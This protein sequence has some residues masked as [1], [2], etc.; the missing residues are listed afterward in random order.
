MP[1]LLDLYHAMPYPLQVLAASLR[2]YR[3]KHLRYGNETERLVAE[4]LERD[5]WSADHWKAWQ[6]ERLAFLLH[7]A[8]TRVPYYRVLWE[9]RRL[10]GDTSSSDILENWPILEKETV[11]RKPE[12]FVA[13]DCDR[14]KMFVDSTSGTTG[15]PLRV[16]LRPETVRQ[17]YALFEARM[18]RKHGVSLKDRWAIMGGQLVAPFDR[19]SPP[20]WVYNHP[21]NQLYLST[22]HLSEHTAADYVAALRRFQPTHMLVYPSSANVLAAAMLKQGLTPP[23]LNVIFTNAEQLLDTQRITIEQAFGCPV[24]N[25]YGLCEI[26]A[27]GGECSTHRMH[28]W[29]EAGLIEILKDEGNARAH[30]GQTG[31]IIAT[32][33]LNADMPLIR[34][35]VGDRGA[36]GA[37]SQCGCGSHL[38]AISALEGRMNDLIVTP[39]GRKVFWLNPTFYGLPVVES[40]IIQEDQRSLRVLIA[41]GQGFCKDHLSTISERLQQRV[42]GMHILYEVVDRVPRTANGKLRGV[43]S[44]LQSG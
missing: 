19:K 14:K 21:L 23:N 20:F 40:Q 5:S 25:T 27:A 1:T 7:R 15:T 39:D 34:Y 4:A 30:P 16:Y 22:H 17:W 3:L 13:D 10:R 44:R 29:P 42:G 32:G 35:Q 28:I 11:R 24:Y 36:V 31:R 43:V 37:G 8:A 33:L 38:P 9:R 12:A 6:E 41:P 18:R 2:G 26:A